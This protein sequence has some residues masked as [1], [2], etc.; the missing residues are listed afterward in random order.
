MSRREFGMESESGARNPPNS[1]C[2]HNLIVF[3][4]K[5]LARTSGTRRR[6]FHTHRNHEPTCFP[7]LSEFGNC[8]GDCF[9]EF[10]PFRNGH[11]PCF[12]LARLIPSTETRAF[13]API[14]TGSARTFVSG[15]PLA[16][17]SAARPPP[18][19]PLLDK[20]L[21]RR[22]QFMAWVPQTQ[23]FTDPRVE[24]ASGGEQGTGR[25]LRNERAGRESDR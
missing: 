24:N 5:P 11:D 13:S 2:Q 8:T 16:I 19:P 23:G 18:R 10:N 17:R 25:W 6:E 7:L 1:N 14:R 4:A 15:S 22:A 20:F 21:S 9:D 12:L 3:T